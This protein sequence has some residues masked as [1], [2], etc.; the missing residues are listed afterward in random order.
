MD[1]YET[2][3]I[4]NNEITEE[5]KKKVID[6]ITDYI[7]KN[8]TITN[9]DDIGTRKLAYEIRKHKDGYY[10]LIEF[11]ADKEAIPELARIYRITDEILKFLIV[12]KDN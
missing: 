3:C 7:K 9:I 6:K 10:Y 5:Q 1:K 11:E 12:R 2:I 4:I 8:G